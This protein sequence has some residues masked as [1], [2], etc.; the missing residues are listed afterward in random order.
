MKCLDVGDATNHYYTYRWNLLSTAKL[1]SLC[2]AS[3]P[4][5]Y[6]NATSDPGLLV[7]HGCCN[8]FMLI[9]Q[10][11]STDENACNNSCSSNAHQLCREAAF[12]AGCSVGLA[13]RLQTQ[14]A[15][16]LKLMCSSFQA[17][18]TS[19]ATMMLLA[20]VQWY[21]SCAPL[22]ARRTGQDPH[23]RHHHHRHRR[24]PRR[25]APWRPGPGRRE[26]R[27]R[28]RP[29]W[30]GLRMWM[31]P[32]LSRP[33]PC[34]GSCTHSTK[35]G[36]HTTSACELET[37]TEAWGNRPGMRIEVQCLFTTS[38]AAGDGACMSA[39]WFSMT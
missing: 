16:R 26:P 35:A 21:T 1:R 7:S 18:L 33:R 4:A 2:L 19:R 14:E 11:S 9:V 3:W 28:P 25:L 23:H 37:V 15:A 32:R 17:P 12:Y 38:A 22:S 13:P 34:L 20:Y 6:G 10:H 5:C 30:P 8:R 29:A 24:Q 27:A 31:H 36:Q 39:L